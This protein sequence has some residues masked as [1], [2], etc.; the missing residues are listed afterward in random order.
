MNKILY[1]VAFV[2]AFTAFKSNALDLVSKA[3]QAQ[4]KIDAVEAKAGEIQ[5]AV[6]AK[7][8]GIPASVEE[9]KAAAQKQ[10]EAKKASAEARRNRYQ[11]MREERKAIRAA[12]GN[13]KTR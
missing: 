8:G 10:I 5:K 7:D 3:E 4:E 6:S 12:K 13:S 11:K 2:L 9:R 1:L